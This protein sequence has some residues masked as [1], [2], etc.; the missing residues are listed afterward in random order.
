MKDSVLTSKLINHHI[1]GGHI[2]LLAHTML[3]RGRRSSERFRST[4]FPSLS[5][6]E[7]VCD[8]VL[9]AGLASF[10]MSRN[11]YGPST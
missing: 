9:V 7:L 6:V 3:T 5:V 11:T 1:S 2:T 8:V 4:V 10:R